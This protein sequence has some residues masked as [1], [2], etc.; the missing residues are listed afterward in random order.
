MLRWDGKRPQREILYYPAQL[1]ERYGAIVS[2]SA[3]GGARG[4]GIDEPP[5]LRRQPAS[6][7]DVSD[8]TWFGVIDYHWEKR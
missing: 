8:E 4:R 3:K 1:R 5:L 6:D 7:K 2:P